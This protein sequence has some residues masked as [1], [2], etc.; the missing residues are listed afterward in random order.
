MHQYFK[1]LQ[2][3][4]SSDDRE[5]KGIKDLTVTIAKLAGYR[6]EPVTLKNGKVVIKTKYNTRVNEN[7]EMV[8]VWDDVL[9]AKWL[10][11]FRG[12]IIGKLS[13]HPELKEFQADIIQRVFSIYFNSL[14]LEKLDFDACVVKSVHTCLNNR[15]GEALFVRGSSSRTKKE[16]NAR[17]LKAGEV[18][19]EELTAAG[20]EVAL[21]KLQNDKT[22]FN[23]SMA[24]LDGLMELKVKVDIG[25]SYTHDEMDPLVMQLKEKLKHSEIGLQ[26]LDAM[27]NSNNSVVRPNS[28]K[29]YIS[30]SNNLTE[31]QKATYISELTTAWNI[32]KD[33]LRESLDQSVADEYD[34]NKKPRF[35]LDKTII[36]K[37]LERKSIHDLSKKY[38]LNEDGLRARFEK[39]KQKDA[40]YAVHTFVNSVTNAIENHLQFKK[41]SEIVALGC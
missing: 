25:G 10:M 34:W 33:T 20:E 11:Y 2:S 14:Q 32:I 15:I 37:R 8:P 35:S 16:E 27:L 29:D 36:Q 28:I 30:I 19:L 24:S 17:R 38:G 1:T 3:V 7:G 18:T 41:N 6:R 4:A 39:M 12:L 9:V 40:D 22:A 31:E 21:H 13:R 5:F 26:L 23:Y